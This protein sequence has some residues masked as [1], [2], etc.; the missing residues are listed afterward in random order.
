MNSDGVV[1]LFYY[2]KWTVGDSGNCGEQWGSVGDCERL[3]ATVGD[4]GGLWGLKGTLGD[5]GAVG[6]CGGRMSLPKTQSVEC[7][8]P[9]PK[10]ASKTTAQ[11]MKIKIHFKNR[12]HLKITCSLF[13]AF[14][15]TAELAGTPS[16]TSSAG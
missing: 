11:K 15:F 6:N 12:I 9:V 7:A 2:R 3:W 10:A 14:I 16:G 1:E 8:D 4:C 13:V 5:W